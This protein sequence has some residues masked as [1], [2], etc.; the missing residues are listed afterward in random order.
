M[1]EFRGIETAIIAA[2]TNCAANS[3]NREKKKETIFDARE[4]LR[5]EAYSSHTASISLTVL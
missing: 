1:I 4:K 2:R 5:D 3:Q